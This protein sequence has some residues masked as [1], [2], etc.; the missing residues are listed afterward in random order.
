MTFEAVAALYR[1]IGKMRSEKKMTETQSKNNPASFDQAK[2]RYAVTYGETHVFTVIVE[3]SN[4]DEAREI[5]ASGNG[6]TPGQP[7]DITTDMEDWNIEEVTTPFGYQV[8]LR[9][10]P[11]GTRYTVRDESDGETSVIGPDGVQLTFEAEMLVRV[12]DDAVDIEH[13]LNEASIGAAHPGL[14]VKMGYKCR[15]IGYGVETGTVTGHFT[16][17]RDDFGK[18][19]F[20]REDGGADLYLFEDE[21]QTVSPV[22]ADDQRECPQSTDGK[23]KPDPKTLIVTHDGD[24]AY[25]DVNCSVC[26]A[27]GCAGKFNPAEIDW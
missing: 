4:E 16:G 8:A 1:V 9:D 18:C 12:P 19:T 21:I 2:R 5:V 27:S 15:D 14:I 23:H 24:G 13:A 25:I 3:A 10:D 6:P 17:H 20:K 26:G 11:N 22:L 7:D